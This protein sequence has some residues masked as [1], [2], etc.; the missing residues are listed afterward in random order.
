MNAII[1]IFSNRELSIIIWLGIAF[2]GL[3]F[4]KQIRQSLFDLL[5]LLCSKTFLTI[6]LLLGVYLFGIII[7]LK[8]IGI[9]S[10]E[11]AKDTIIWLFTVG[12]VL[13]FNTTKEKGS[14]YFL[15]VVKEGLKW[16]VFLEFIL[17][18]YSFSLII[19]L[20]LIP[21][22]T[23]LFL[24]YTVSKTDAKNK[25]VT[26]LLS[27]ILNL[28]GLVIFSYTL[29]KTVVSYDMLFTYSTLSSFFLPIIITILFLPFIYLTSLYSTY[30]TFFVRL[31]FMSS[32]KKKIKKIK[33]II[34]KSSGL[35]LN[36]LNRII[37]KFDKKV[38]YQNISFKKYIND[39]SNKPK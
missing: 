33:K 6:Y 8:I 38:F 30:E 14:K 18:F 19:E 7:L 28:F 24:T 35:N 22:I 37:K 39:I 10:I 36:K 11:D 13:L 17:N 23:F 12:F 1:N 3:L 31:N 20:I 2:I 32:E 25:Q 27:V 34:I 21:F 29:Y 15:N 9:W 16:S 26:K 5:R 4:S